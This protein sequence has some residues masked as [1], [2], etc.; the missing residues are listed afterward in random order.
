VISAAP[1][2]LPFLS[3]PLESANQG[4][5]LL[6]FQTG[7][8]PFPPLLLGMPRP[9]MASA[10]R[11]RTLPPPLASLFLGGYL[12]S[13]PSSCLPLCSHIASTHA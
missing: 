3:S 6:A 11:R 1:G 2:H 12:R 4:G 7:H 13:S 5:I 10:G 9:S 8:F